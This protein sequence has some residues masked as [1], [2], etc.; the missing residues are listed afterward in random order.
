MSARSAVARRPVSSATPGRNGVL[1]WDAL[2]SATTS[3]SRAHSTTSR[4]ASRSVCARAVPHAP[5]PTMPTL[6]KVTVAL[7][8]HPSLGPQPESRDLGRHT[9]RLGPGSRIF[10]DANSGMTLRRL[11]DEG[12]AAAGAVVDPHALGLQVAL[13]RF[14]AVLAAEARGLVAAERHGE[15]H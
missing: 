5:P 11:H 7:P 1:A 3:A 8:C 4:P 14:D 10:A 15:A 13:D 6:S 12:V 2:I 9:R